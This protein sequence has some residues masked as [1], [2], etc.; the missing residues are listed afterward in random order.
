M[1]QQFRLVGWSADC[2]QTTAHTHTHI[3]IGPINIKWAL[4]KYGH[5][6][7]LNDNSCP[8]VSLLIYIYSIS[9]IFKSKRRKRRRNEAT[10]KTKQNETERNKEHC[11]IFCITKFILMAAELR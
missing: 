8:F 1:N 4:T 10:N 5:F 11:V 3:I 7:A 9:L 6:Q 2:G